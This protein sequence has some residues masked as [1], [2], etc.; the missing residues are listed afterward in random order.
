[1]A[2]IEAGDKHRRIRDVTTR[3]PHSGRSSSKSTVRTFVTAA[4]RLFD[5]RC[6]RDGRTYNPQEL[7]ALIEAETGERVSHQ[8]IRQI[9]SGTITNATIAYVDILARFFGVP[10][11]YFFPGFDEQ[12]AERVE[13]QLGLLAAMQQAGIRS[14]AAL[15]AMSPASLRIARLADGVSPET[16]NAIGVMLSDARKAQRLDEGEATPSTEVSPPEQ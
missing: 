2:D 6:E 13:A 15:G 3:R 9:R 10:S 12:T 1:M 5:L 8:W 11:A 14:I 4:N 7:A 16:L